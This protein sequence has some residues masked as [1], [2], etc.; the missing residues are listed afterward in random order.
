[1]K[2]FFIISD[3]DGGGTQRV[4]SLLSNQMIKKNSVVICTIT[5]SKEFFKIDKKIKRIKLNFLK[6][7]Q[8]FFRVFNFFKKIFTIR[9]LLK[10]YN[11]YTIISLI[12]G[13]N[14]IVLIALLFS[15]KKLIICERND[16]RKQKV[17]SLTNFLRFITYGLANAVTTNLESNIKNLNYLRKKKNTFFTKPSKNT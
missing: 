9:R 15:N 3:M 2:V 7:K 13:T 17:S 10:E 14:I 5:K 6:K 1:M 11:D 12:H 4:V 16:V 8:I